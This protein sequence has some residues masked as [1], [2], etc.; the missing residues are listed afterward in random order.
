MAHAL[1]RLLRCSPCGAGNK[2][3]GIGRINLLVDCQVGPVIIALIQLLTYLAEVIAA[4]RE[5]VYP[6][7]ILAYIL[8]QVIIEIASSDLCLGANILI[9]IEA[10]CIVG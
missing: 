1:E 3:Y 2:L 6:L 4:G 10:P 8:S 9:H 7:Q 5:L